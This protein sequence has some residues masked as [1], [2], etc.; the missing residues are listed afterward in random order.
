[1]RKQGKLYDTRFFFEHYYSNDSKALEKTKQEIKLT[2]RKYISAI[3]LH[4]LHLLTLGKDG[5]ETAELR[6]NLL[7]KDFTTVNVNRQI[8]ETSA[9]LRHR[10]NIPMADSMIAATAKQLNLTC[11]TD[12]PHITKIKEIK[13]SWIT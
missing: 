12:D 2:K 1:M 5:R 10:T 13:T 6:I 9:E 8:A 7:T 4:E 3:V 11:V